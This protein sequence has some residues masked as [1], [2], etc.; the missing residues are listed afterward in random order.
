MALLVTGLLLFTV[1][2][3]LPAVSPDMRAGLVAKLGDNAY[4]AMFSILIL[5]SL[6]VIVFGWKAATPTGIYAPPMR[7]DALISALVFFAFVLFVASKARSNYRRFVRHPQMV[8]VILWSVAHL[9]VSGDSRSVV[10]FGGL[11]IWAVAEIVLCNKRD[12]AWKKPDVAPLSADI[13]VAVI[14]GVAFGIFFYLHRALF[15]VLPYWPG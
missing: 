8:S 14:A 4:Q 9:L 15:G 1:V 6:V 3:L 5:V 2:H 7:G 10:L 11:G 12:G 13:V